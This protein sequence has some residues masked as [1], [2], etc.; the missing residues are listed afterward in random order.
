MPKQFLSI[1]N[2]GRGINN[3]KN[4]RDLSIGEM[5]DCR[6]WNVSKN[7]ELVPRSEWNTENDNDAYRIGTNY[8]DNFT[9]SL[10]PGYGLFYFEADD[11][12][13]VRGASIRA[14]GSTG[15]IGQGPDGN[16]EY[17]FLIVIKYLLMMIIFGLLIMLFREFLLV[18]YQ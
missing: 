6:N 12:I 15:D 2:F 8:V 17:T 16:S 9:A 11:P 3:V 18:I 4:P 10:N 13:G 5:A 7:G 14:N 1:N